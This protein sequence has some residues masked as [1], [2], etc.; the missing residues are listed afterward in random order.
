MG[1]QKNVLAVEERYEHTNS[2]MRNRAARNL[3]VRRSSR[4]WFPPIH[5]LAQLVLIPFVRSSQIMQVVSISGHLN[6]SMFPLPTSFRLLES[7]TMRIGHEYENSSLVAVFLS[8]CHRCLSRLALL[9]EE[10]QQDRK[11]TDRPQNPEC[12]DISKD[13]SLLLQQIVCMPIGLT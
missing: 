1:H 9:R 3:W 10:E 6:P 12:I 2:G 13:C 4:E 8:V 5:T 11:Q 7:P